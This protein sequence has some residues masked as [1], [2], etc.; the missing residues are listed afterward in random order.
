VGELGVSILRP[1]GG[2]AHPQRP[3]LSPD[4]RCTAKEEIA[5]IPLILTTLAL[6]LLAPLAVALMRVYVL[7]PVQV[8]IVTRRRS[9]R[10][11]SGY[12][13]GQP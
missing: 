12:R 2:P 11:I 10:T 9:L 7:R 3:P 5:M 13:E 1:A 8:T 4:G 6:G